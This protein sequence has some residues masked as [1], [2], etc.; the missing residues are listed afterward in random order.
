MILE[1]KLKTKPISINDAYYRAGQLKKEARVY[2]YDVLKQLLAF[3]DQIKEFR[4]Y[5]LPL[6]EESGH[7][8]QLSI[9]HNIPEGLFFTKSGQISM[10]SGD[11]DNLLKLLIDFLF[12]A[13]YCAF[14]E[15]M[16]PKPQ[17]ELAG[18]YLTYNIGIDD[19]FIQK[20]ETIKRPTKDAQWSVDI[21]VQ[22]VPL[23]F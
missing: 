13:R 4:D 20:I 15:H 3:K 7:A 16:G 21:T 17:F 10:R 18:G 12:N 22:T 6:I 9:V 2:R 23:I 11:V 1:L 14:L 19:R 8:L 5:T